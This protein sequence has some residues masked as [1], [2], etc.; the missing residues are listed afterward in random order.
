M[1]VKCVFWFVEYT[2]NGILQKT[3]D[4]ADRFTMTFFVLL[5]CIYRKF[6][7]I[8]NLVFHGGVYD[9]RHAPGQFHIVFGGVNTIRQT[10][11]MV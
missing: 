3:V 1:D 9:A 6:Y 2:E 10:I 11:G 7:N 4:G 8:L 5:I